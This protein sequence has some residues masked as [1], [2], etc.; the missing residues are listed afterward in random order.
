MKQ[1]Q[2]EEPPSQ[3]PTLET[4][5]KTTCKNEQVPR[6]ERC[7]TSQSQFKN[8]TDTLGVTKESVAIQ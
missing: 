1:L 2:K 4:I 6:D 7:H 5:K 8:Q 3:L